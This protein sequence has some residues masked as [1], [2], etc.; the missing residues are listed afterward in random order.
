MLTVQRDGPGISVV[1]FSPGGKLL[2]C[3]NNVSDP[4]VV[5]DVASGECKLDLQTECEFAS[6]IFSADGREMACGVRE[7]MLIVCDIASGQIYERGVHDGTLSMAEFLLGEP[8]KASPEG[9]LDSWHLASGQSGPTFGARLRYRFCRVIS[10]DGRRTAF[11]IK[12]NTSAEIRDVASGMCTQQLHGEGKLIDC[13]AF[14]PDSQRLVV[15]LRDGTIKIWD[16]KGGEAIGQES[17]KAAEPAENISDIT[18]SPDGQT[19]VSTSMGSRT[20]RV[21]DAASGQCKFTFQGDPRYAPEIAFSA[22][23][24]YFA[25]ASRR[26]CEVWD[27]A[28]A[29]CKHTVHSPDSATSAVALSPSGQ[30]LALGYQDD[31]CRIQDLASRQNTH[32]PT[33]NMWSV[34]RVKF[35]PNGS[36]LVLFICY[37]KYCM[38]WDV[39]RRQVQQ[40]IR[41]QDFAY[42]IAFSP[43]GRTLMIR[44]STCISI[45]DVESGQCIKQVV[46]SAG[47]LLGNDQ[48]PLDLT[49]TW[50][51]SMSKDGCWLTLNGQQI[52]WIPTMF[53]GEFARSG[54]RVAFYDSTRGQILVLDMM[55]HAKRAEAESSGSLSQANSRQ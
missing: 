25:S 28:S 39:A 9:L 54:Q 10:P 34:E 6:I 27:V 37:D 51:Y 12:G 22:D 50:N 15:G 36:L 24:R 1:A 55:L 26:V 40:Q 29:E 31:S 43:D 32:L 30:L 5:L 18:F 38:V 20:G 44:H 19:L 41:L 53:R 52:V 17:Q 4:V 14:S 3:T 42:A 16:V 8:Q 33:E 46:N 49:R 13:M 2:A 11:G 35:S 48:S 47:L 45:W 21:W 7:N 23:S